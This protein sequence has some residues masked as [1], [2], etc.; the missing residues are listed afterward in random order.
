[1]TARAAEL[2]AP[3]V[4]AGRNVPAARV[5][6]AAIYETYFDFVWR[7]IRQLG[8]TGASVDDAVQDVF[9][10]V[11]RRL[12]DF[13]ARSSMRTWLFGIALRVGR[14][15]R[16]GATRRGIAEPLSPELT[17]TTPSPHQNAE[18]AEALALL[19]RLLDAMDERK[20]EV[21]FLAE[22]EQLTAPEIAE[23]LAIPLNT[24]YSRLRVARQ[25][26]EQALRELDGGS[27]ARAQ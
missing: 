23:T 15:Y 25:T 6:F 7:T 21:F 5:D 10:V 27:D 17:D 13:E 11:H 19:A 18:A 22:V 1:M 14:N 3:L 12:G 4:D 20:R 24:V 9:V 26:F 16:R 2:A 8:V